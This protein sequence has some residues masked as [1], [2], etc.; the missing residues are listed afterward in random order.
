MVRG[1]LE[2][3]LGTLGYMSVLYLLI[4]LRVLDFYSL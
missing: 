2:N 1:K 4:L 3:W